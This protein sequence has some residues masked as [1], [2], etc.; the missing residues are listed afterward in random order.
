MRKDE[1]AHN[2]ALSSMVDTNRMWLFNFE[3]KW[4]KSK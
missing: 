2:P 4:I 3:Y 1:A